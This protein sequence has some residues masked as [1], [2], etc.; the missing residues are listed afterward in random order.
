MYR[1]SEKTHDGEVDGKKIQIKETQGKGSIVIREEPEYLL[2]EFL[3][4]ETGEISKIYNGPGTLAWQFR[5]YVQNMN[6]YTI[7]ATN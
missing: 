6:H 3:D 4:K 1:Q 5:S 7:C 2:V